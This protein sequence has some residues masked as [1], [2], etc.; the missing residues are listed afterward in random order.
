M[1]ILGAVIEAARVKTCGNG[2]RFNDDGI[3][4]VGVG[5]NAAGGSYLD[6]FRVNTVQ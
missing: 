2:F 3:E 4:S 1:E 5:D 6:S